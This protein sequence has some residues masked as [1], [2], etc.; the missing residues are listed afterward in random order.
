MAES[1][2]GDFPSYSYFARACV[3]MATPLDYFSTGRNYRNKQ[4][5][6]WA[7]SLERFGLQEPSSGATT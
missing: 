7:M 1:G 5:F 6:Y 2:Q 3:A 4:S